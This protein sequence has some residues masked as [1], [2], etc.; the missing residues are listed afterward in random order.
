[1][2]YLR[3][4]AIAATM[5]FASSVA[6][7]A[8]EASFLSGRVVGVSDGDTI[9]VLSAGNVETRIRLAYI[10]APEKSQAFGQQSKKSLSD[11]VY[12]KDVTIEVIDTDRYG[13]KVG[14]VHSGPPDA[15]ADRFGV[16]K[17]QVDRG[18][19]WVYRRYSDDPVLIRAESTA[20]N[21]KIGLWADPQPIPPWDYRRER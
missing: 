9:K 21:A 13:R 10:D 7:V 3:L 20:R 16:N 8:G 1:M 4:A 5:F 15:V 17:T 18:L 19:A 14:V 2:K 6:A 12:G 11:M